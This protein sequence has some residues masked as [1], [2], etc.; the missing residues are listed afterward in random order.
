[1]SIERSELSVATCTV[2]GL[3]LDR[4][5]DIADGKVDFMQV[6]AFLRADRYTF[7]IVALE[8]RLSDMQAIR[9]RYQSGEGK[10]TVRVGHKFAYLLR[11]VVG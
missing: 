1:M 5:G 3:D 11:E 8:S 7:L 2:F 9:P 10:R 6:H 4:A